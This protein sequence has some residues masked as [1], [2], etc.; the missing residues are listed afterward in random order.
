MPTTSLYALRKVLHSPLDHIYAIWKRTI[1]LPKYLFLGLSQDL[2]QFDRGVAAVAAKFHKIPVE[3]GASLGQLEDF[4]GFSG[5]DLVVHP[6]EF[7][8]SATWLF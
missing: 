5:G 3:L 4:G 7:T 8:P 6:A 1:L 2:C